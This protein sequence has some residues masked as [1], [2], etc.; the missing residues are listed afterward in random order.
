[1]FLRGIAPCYSCSIWG[2]EDAGRGRRETER[3]R[4]RG[5][6]GKEGVQLEERKGERERGEERWRGGKG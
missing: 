3:N 2:E 4:G 1:M 5:E 6:R